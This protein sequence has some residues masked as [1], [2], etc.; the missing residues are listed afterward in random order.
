MVVFYSRKGK[1]RAP[2][3]LCLVHYF[4]HCGNPIKVRPHPLEGRN[5]ANSMR[6]WKLQVATGGSSRSAGSGSNGCNGSNGKKYRR[7]CQQRKLAAN[8]GGMYYCR[9]LPPIAAVARTRKRSNARD[10]GSGGRA[11]RYAHELSWQTFWFKG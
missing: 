7:S 1:L 10:R 5:P 8:G 2:F 11:L 9:R 3:S 4:D 6:P